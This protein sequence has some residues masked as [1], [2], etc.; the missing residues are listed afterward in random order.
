[1]RKCGKRYASA[2]A[3]R[4]SKLGR[5]NPALVPERCAC[6]G[7]HLRAA[8]KPVTRA[9]ARGRKDTIPPKV[10]KLVY[11]RDGGACVQCG[12]TRDLHE[13]HRRIKGHGGDPRPHTDCPCNIV[14][15]CAAHHE[16]A[17][18]GSRAEAEA[19]GL[20]VKRSVLFPGS[21]PVMISS[22][23][24]AGATVHLPCDRPYYS[25]AAP[26]RSAA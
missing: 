15:V 11:D 12:S 23:A 3:A 22:A 10:R 5:T 8:R 18:R 25:T 1:M 26:G 16:E 7:W 4:V 9:K 17:H 19:T 14:L 21:V 13:H 6:G 20:I 2:E 24:G